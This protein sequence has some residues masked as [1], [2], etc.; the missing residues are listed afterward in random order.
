MDDITFGRNGCD[1]KR[2]RMHSVNAI[3]DVA[4]MGRSLMSMNACC[5]TVSR[6]ILEYTVIHSQLLSLVTMCAMPGLL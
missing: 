2:W 3:N 1:A 5:Y 6:N 4:I